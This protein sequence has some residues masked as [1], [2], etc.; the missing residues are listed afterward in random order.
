VSYVVKF[1]DSCPI[2]YDNKGK[3]IAGA[4]VHGI[5]FPEV[6]VNTPNGEVNHIAGS[7]TA[8]ISVP[9]GQTRKCIKGVSI[10]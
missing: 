10:V 7:G 3:E 1:V 5:H 4:L 9:N 8:D 6:T 2:V